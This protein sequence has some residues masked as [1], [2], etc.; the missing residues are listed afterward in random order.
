MVE[1]KNRLQRKVFF[2]SFEIAKMQLRHFLLKQDNAEDNRSSV[3]KT[4]F[5]S[6][7]S[8]NDCS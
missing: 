4:S 3:P 6:L 7:I 1:K 5:F 2:F 8:I